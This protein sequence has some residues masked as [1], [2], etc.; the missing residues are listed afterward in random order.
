LEKKTIVKIRKNLYRE[1]LEKCLEL[2]STSYEV[3]LGFL[4]IGLDEDAARQKAELADDTKF[5]MA[6]Y[7]WKGAN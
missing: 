3:Y 4:E 5:K 1:N 2:L 6:F 7:M